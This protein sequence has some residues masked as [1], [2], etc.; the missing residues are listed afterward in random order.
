MNN[1][2]C[3][4]GS[5]TDSRTRTRNAIREA[6][7][8]MVTP[9]HQ[10]PRRA[11]RCCGRAGPR[12]Q[13]DRAPQPQVPD[14][15]RGFP[16]APPRTTPP[17]SRPRCRQH[18]E[19]LRS[20]VRHRPRE[21]HVVTPDISAT[22]VAIR[23]LP[24]TPVTVGSPWLSFPTL[25]SVAAGRI[26]GLPVGPAPSA[27]GDAGWAARSGGR[28]RPG[29][30]HRERLGGRAALLSGSP[31][32]GGAHSSARLIRWATQVGESG[33]CYA[34]AQVI[35]HDRNGDRRHPS[36]LG[37]PPGRVDNRASA[38]VSERLDGPHVRLPDRARPSWTGCA[39]PGR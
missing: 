24:V 23:W 3:W 29:G 37:E 13:A 1:T 36:A 28:R 5:A 34:N 25:R 9:D 30:L 35:D 10:T 17:P 32:V 20:G 12:H 19:P 2:G 4:G 38:P 15:P 8:Q 39:C 33:A 26:F 31:L 21:Q 18:S 16:D 11:I 22:A 7:C 27:G 14:K 6:G